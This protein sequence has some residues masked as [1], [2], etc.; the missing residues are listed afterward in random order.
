MKDG[1]IIRVTR[2]PE[3]P[4]PLGVSG[5]EV[6]ELEKL[7]Q[8]YPWLSESRLQAKLILNHLLFPYGEDIHLKMEMIINEYL[9]GR[10][11]E[12]EM[13]RRFDLPEREGGVNLYTQR[14]QEITKKIVKLVN[15]IKLLRG[16]YTEKLSIQEKVKKF[17]EFLLED[18]NVSLSLQQIERLDK[19]LAQR[20]LEKITGED[21]KELLDKPFR[22][23]G[24]GLNRRTAEKL[25]NKS[26]I[27]LMK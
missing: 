5:G 20:M 16:E 17:R 4:M 3:K 15:Q 9:Q 8:F 23:G 12:D 21:F 27:I 26:E 2:N 14:A 6:S 22:S 1:Q 11:T 19:F 10:I 25:F 7:A 13:F 18:C 24:V